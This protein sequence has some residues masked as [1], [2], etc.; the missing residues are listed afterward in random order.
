M[1]AHPAFVGAKR[2]VELHPEAA[3]DLDLSLV[4]CPRNAKNDLSFRLADPLD[5]RQIEVMGVFGHH[6]PQ[7]FQHFVHGLVKFRLAGIAPG[8][9]GQDGLQLFVD[10]GHVFTIGGEHSISPNFYACSL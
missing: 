4:V 2:R 10:V 7:A 9:L 8:H 3:I 5:Q 6:A 1:K